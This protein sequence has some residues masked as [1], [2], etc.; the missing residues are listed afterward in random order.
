MY[1]KFLLGGSSSPLSTMKKLTLIKR[2]GL[3]HPINLMASVRCTEEVIILFRIA[4]FNEADL[5]I[6]RDFDIKAIEKYEN[7]C[8]L[9]TS[10]KRAIDAFEYLRLDSKPLIVELE[11]YFNPAM[12]DSRLLISPQ[13]FFPTQRVVTDCLCVAE[14]EHGHTLIAS[15]DILREESV[16]SM[17]LTIPI[18]ILSTFRDSKFPG[19]DLVAQGLHPDIAFLLYLIYLRDNR[20][21]LGLE[22]HRDFFR[23]QPNNY[24]TLFELPLD[25]IESMEEPEMIK[26]IH[27][28]NESLKSICESLSP[29]PSFEDLLWAK[30]LCTSRAFSLSIPPTDDFEKSVIAK[31]YPEGQITTLLPF[32]HFFNHH[33][34]AQCQTPVV[35]NNRVHIRSLV[36][37]TKGQEVFI[38]YGGMNNKELM[39]NYGFCV[40][41]NPYDSTRGKDGRIVRRGSTRL[42]IQ[43][44]IIET[45]ETIFQQYLADKKRFISSV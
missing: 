40:P 22:I 8:N 7:P 23:I 41:G 4:N 45:S 36:S 43:P 39:L 6:C 13:S 33:F 30:S 16:I 21:T 25:M 26:D 19:K 24:G 27:N 28:Q 14:G 38:I 34:R 9:R 20:E 32:V 37:V 15:R 44:E 42:P 5:E 18:S 12:G 35:E 31:F 1:S 29:P 3:C 11:S 10:L 2:L 17:D